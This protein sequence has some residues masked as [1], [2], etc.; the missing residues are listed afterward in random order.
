MKKGNF[1]N[2]GKWHFATAMNDVDMQGYYSTNVDNID[3]IKTK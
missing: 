1:I 2:F 3:Y